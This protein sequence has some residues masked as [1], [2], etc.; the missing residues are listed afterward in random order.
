MSAPTTST[1]SQHL[2]R[3]DL[4]TTS[5]WRTHQREQIGS[6]Q[7][8]EGATLAASHLVALDH[9]PAGVAIAPRSYVEADRPRLWDRVAPAALRAA[10]RA[11]AVVGIVAI[12]ATVGVDAVVG[13]I[14][15]VVAVAAALGALGGAIGA[16]RDHRR[17]RLRRA[18]GQ[19][20][21]LRPTAFDVV[22]DRAVPG[23]RHDLATW[24]DP[25]ALPVQ[26]DRPSGAFCRPS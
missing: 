21:D 7:T 6:F 20:P 24:W 4:I 2:D 9:E 23:A 14:L 5:G 26:R 16:V 11:T 15:P 25:S 12:G 1:T 13:V 10:G 18:P 17:A 19:P 8:M 3:A 22:V